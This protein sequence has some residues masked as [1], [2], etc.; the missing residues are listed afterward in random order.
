MYTGVGGRPEG[1]RQLV[2]TRHRWEMNIKMFI[3]E[4]GWGGVHWIHMAP[5]KYQ[6]RDFMNTA[7]SL[8]FKQNVGNLNSLGTACCLFKND[9][10]RCAWV[11]LKYNIV[12]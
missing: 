12:N 3:Q 11:Q 10:Q 8:R 9:C 5:S 4:V 6:T 2:R 7:T 1:K